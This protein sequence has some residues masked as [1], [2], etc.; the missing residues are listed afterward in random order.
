M[1]DTKDILARLQAGERIEDIAQ[2]AADAL[3][4]AKAEYDKIEAEKKVA[5]AKAEAEKKALQ[6]KKE[7]GVTGIVSG[8]VDYINQFYPTFFDAADLAEFHRS[9]DAGALVKA[10]DQTIEEIESIPAVAA[11]L[12]KGAPKTT[13][14]LSG[15]DAKQAEDVF[16]KFF[17]ENN[18]F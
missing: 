8:I 13:V 17:E 5:A 2:K 18:I 7:Q 4:S 6:E 10:F 9:F 15:K 12:K 16:N 11:A 14:K 3:N 1:F